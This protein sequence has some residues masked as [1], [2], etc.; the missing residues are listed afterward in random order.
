MNMFR[1]KDRTRCEFKRKFFIMRKFSDV[2]KQS[3]QQTTIDVHFHNDLFI[4]SVNY[5][6]W[7]QHRN[8]Y[9]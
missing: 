4:D 9:N 2:K 1:N 5:I 6:I 3:S 8:R 7:L